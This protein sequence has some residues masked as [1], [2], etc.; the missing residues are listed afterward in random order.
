MKSIWN[1]LE[2]LF[3][4]SKQYRG[5]TAWTRKQLDD[6][7]LGEPG[8]GLTGRPAKPDGEAFDCDYEFNPNIWGKWYPNQDPALTMASTDKDTTDQH[9]GKSQGGMT[10]KTNWGGRVVNVPGKARTDFERLPSSMDRY[11][12]L[13]QGDVEWKDVVNK[14]TQKIEKVGKGR[15]LR[16]AYSPSIGSADERRMR[17]VT[18]IAGKDPGPLSRRPQPDRPEPTKTQITKWDREHPPAQPV[19]RVG[20]NLK[21]QVGDDDTKLPPSGGS[22]ASSD[23]KQRLAKISKKFY[24]DE[25]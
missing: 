2:S 13:M 4:E 25:D 1:I 15:L 7:L 23:F 3:Q 12:I 5:D 10:F 19:A 21:T 22:Q 14:K 16:M 8:P 18:L 11:D 9:A 17:L 20:Q 6:L 24:K